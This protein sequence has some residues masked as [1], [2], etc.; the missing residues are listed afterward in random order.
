MGSSENLEAKYR[1]FEKHLDREIWVVTSADGD[2]KGG[3]IATFVS[4]AS[5][6]A[7]LPRVLAGISRRHQTWEL[8]EASG[9][10]A[11]HLLGEDRLD[12]VPR[13]GLQSGRT[14]DK[15]AG[16]EHHPGRS[17]SPILAGASGW[18]DC[19]VEARLETGDR[20]M[21]LAEVVDALAPEDTQVLTVQR[22]LRLVSEDVRARLAEDLQRDSLVDAAAIRF[23][24][25]GGPAD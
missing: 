20:T 24:R 17:G 25:D 19:R 18:L 14:V 8:I 10:F 16:L 3:L 12:W 7:S 4:P 6:A 15:L 22:M 21:Y 9:S 5:I 11:V 23:W 2:R 1:A 13:F